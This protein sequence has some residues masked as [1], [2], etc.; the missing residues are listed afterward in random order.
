MRAFKDGDYTFGTR[1]RTTAG[2]RSCCIPEL[3]ALKR[4]TGTFVFTL[5]NKQSH[6][7]PAVFPQ[8]SAAD[9]RIKVP[10]A[11]NPELTRLYVLLLKPGVGQNIA[12]VIYS[13]SEYLPST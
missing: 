11:E 4:C 13:R 9:T 7:F 8:K 6:L 12:M 5:Y 2:A 1:V 3:L 10:S